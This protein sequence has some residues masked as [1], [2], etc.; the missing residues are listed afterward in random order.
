MREKLKEYAKNPHMAPI[1]AANIQNR[2][3]RDLTLIED[4]CLNGRLEPVPW[5]F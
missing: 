5:F 1:G 4:S 3:I 2:K